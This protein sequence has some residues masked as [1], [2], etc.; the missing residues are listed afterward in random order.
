[1][2]LNLSFENVSLE[3]Y[4]TL[5]CQHRRNIYQNLNVYTRNILVSSFAVIGFI[6]VLVNLLV[7][8]V[9]HRTK[10]LNVQS[11][12]LFHI[13]SILDAFTSSINFVHLKAFFDPYQTRCEVYYVLSFLLHWGIYSSSFMVLI[14]G[15][16][17]YI[18]VKYLIDYKVIFTSLRFKMVLVLYFVCVIYQSSITAFMVILKGPKTAGPYT[19]PLSVLGL[20]GITYLYS[21]SIIILKK[22]S[23]D[24]ID[25]SPSKR[26]IVKI[27]VFY[28]YFYLI[29]I[30]ILLV[31]QALANWTGVTISVDLN[32]QSVLGIIYTIAPTITTIVNALAFLLINKKS[33]VWLKSCFKFNIKNDLKIQPRNKSSSK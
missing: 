27:A 22:H 2:S 14:T 4:N 17:R 20:I 33:C 6:G 10:Q 15:L 11:I 19:M 28:F 26:N 13:F 24:S 21:K 1:M 9:I 18:H 30:T 3:S 32:G 16:D 5:F 7:V 23:K 12:Q 25:I 8:F 29:N 31:F